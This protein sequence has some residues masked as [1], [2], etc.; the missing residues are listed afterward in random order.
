MVTKTNKM[1]K[2]R[3]L[4]FASMLL[5]VASMFYFS[6]CKKTVENLID[7][8]C[9]KCTHPT[10]VEQ[11]NVCNA[12]GVTTSTDVYESQGYTCKKK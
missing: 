4:P 7:L 1:M 8:E 5:L 3:V 11:D 10:E 9:F 12:A 2:K 6:G